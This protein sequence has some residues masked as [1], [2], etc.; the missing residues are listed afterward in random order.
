MYN[1]V[2]NVSQF[3]EGGWLRVS[4]SP[5]HLEDQDRTMEGQELHGALGEGVECAMDRARK[6]PSKT[7]YKRLRADLERFFRQLGKAYSPGS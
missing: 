5:R 3:K 2:S 4:G 6:G 1:F 7:E